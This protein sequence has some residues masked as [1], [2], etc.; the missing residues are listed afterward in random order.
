MRPIH[1]HMIGH[2]GE[3]QQRLVHRAQTRLQNIDAINHLADRPQ[4]LAEWARVLKPGG[5]LLFTD[6]HLRPATL[7]RPSL[8]SV[9]DTK[10]VAEA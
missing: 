10:A 1:Q 2:L 4:V 5:R 3:L 7:A 6:P 9:A 8:R